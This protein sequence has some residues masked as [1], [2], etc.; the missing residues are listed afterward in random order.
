[1][2]NEIS[3]RSNQVPSLEDENAECMNLELNVDADRKDTSVIEPCTEDISTF[4][5]Y[6]RP[7]FNFAAY[8]NN[9]P[10]LQELIKLGVNLH[11]LE[12]RKGVPEFILQMDFNQNMKEHIR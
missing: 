5:P 12:R 2:Q 3:E 7:S 10:V 6:I 9:S 4:S 11:R 8:I 1:M